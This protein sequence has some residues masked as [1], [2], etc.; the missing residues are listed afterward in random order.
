MK[1][2]ALKYDMI[3]AFLDGERRHPQTAMKSL[4]LDGYYHARPESIADCWFFF[5]SE[6]PTTE[7]PPWIK[8][9]EFDERFVKTQ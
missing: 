8:K 4:G 9:V 3:D 7:L 6:W 2:K 1:L 5:F